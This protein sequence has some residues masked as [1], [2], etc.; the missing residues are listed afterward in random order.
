MKPSGDFLTRSALLATRKVIG[1]GARQLTCRFVG[2]TPA[3]HAHGSSSSFNSYAPIERSLKITGLWE[4]IV[5]ALRQCLSMA[6][7]SEVREAPP[8]SKSSVVA[9][10]TSLVTMTPWCSR[11]SADFPRPRSRRGRPS[12]PPS[13]NSRG[14]STAATRNLSS[15]MLLNSRQRK[16]RSI[17]RQIGRRVG[18]S[19]GPRLD[20]VDSVG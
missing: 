18:E 9:S 10:S 5:R 1:G 13:M 14:H 16:H 7:F 3:L 11:S 6:S 12:L 8:T 20:P 17:F 4:A 15:S 2:R 19:S